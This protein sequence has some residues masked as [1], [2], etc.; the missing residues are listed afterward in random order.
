MDELV[1]LPSSPATG[2]FDVPE[3]ERR[4]EQRAWYVYDWA[5]SAYVTTTATVLLAPFLTSVAER[6]ACPGTSGGADCASDLSV[7]GVPVSPGSLV[8]YAATF[9]TLLSAGLLPLVGAAVDRSGRQRAVLAGSAW[10]GSL[11]AAAMWFVAG[12]R[13]QLGVALFVVA[14]LCLAASLV[15]YDAVLCRIATPDERDRVSSRGWAPITGRG[16]AGQARACRAPKRSQEAWPMRSMR[17]WGLWWCS[18]S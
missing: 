10:A 9:S 15:T 5:N 3:D 11:A 18:R 12:T 2:P 4:R 13:W 6:A 8:F 17:C 16:Q 7:L 1:D 14:N